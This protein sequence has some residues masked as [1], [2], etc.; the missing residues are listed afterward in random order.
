MNTREKIN[1]SS[2]FDFPFQS[3]FDFS[4]GFKLPRSCTLMYIYAYPTNASMCSFK[5][6]SLRKIKGIEEGSIF[7]S[8]KVKALLI[9]ALDI[10][11]DEYNESQDLLYS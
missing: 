3:I 5:V 7:P 11:Q 6:K 10:T 9:K 1:C 2:D 4:I 8:K